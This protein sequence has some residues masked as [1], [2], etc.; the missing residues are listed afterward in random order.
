MTTSM[1]DPTGTETAAAARRG[2]VG[3]LLP[4]SIAA[5]GPGIR[6]DARDQAM[7]ALTYR[8]IRALARVADLEWLSGLNMPSVRLRARPSTGRADRAQ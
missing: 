3:G 4:H 7:Q 5:F 1:Q 6:G 8:I 2:P